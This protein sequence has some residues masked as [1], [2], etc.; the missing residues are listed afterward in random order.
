MSRCCVR[1]ATTSSP[2]WRSAPRAEWPPG[3][4]PGRRDTERRSNAADE[5]PDDTVRR[6]P[7]GYS[8]TAGT[9]TAP[10]VQRTSYVRLL[11]TWGVA[12]VVVAAAFVGLSVVIH[13][14]PARYVCPPDCGHPPIGEPVTINPRFTA[15]DG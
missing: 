6:H 14:P 11:R 13:K 2:I 10:P 5:Q 15:P 4:H 12:I 8:V 3:Q 9:Y 7:P 1:T